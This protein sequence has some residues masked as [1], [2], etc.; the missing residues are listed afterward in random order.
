MRVES[1]GGGQEVPLAVGEGSWVDGQRA[2]DGQ[3]RVRRADL[4]RPTICYESSW[5][6]L[7][8]HN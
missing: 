8:E 2:P 1:D 4:K 7:K 6:E 3:P 5:I